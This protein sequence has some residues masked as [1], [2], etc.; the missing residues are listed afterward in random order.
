MAT[1][2]AIVGDTLPA[3]AGEDSFNILPTWDWVCRENQ[4]GRGESVER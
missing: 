4:P 2:A 1:A 3:N